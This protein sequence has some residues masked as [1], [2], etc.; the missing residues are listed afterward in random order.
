MFSGHSEGP[1]SGGCWPLAILQPRT[2]ILVSFALDFHVTFGLK[3]R[4]SYTTGV[5]GETLFSRKACTSFQIQMLLGLGRGRAW[6]PTSKPSHPSLCAQRTKEVTSDL[7]GGEAGWMADGRWERDH[8]LTPTASLS[9]ISWKQLWVP[10]VGNPYA[11]YALLGLW[12]GARG[13]H[14][15]SHGPLAMISVPQNRTPAPVKGKCTG[16]SLQTNPFSCHRAI[17]SQRQLSELQ[18]HL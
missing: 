13:Y 17:A 10:P 4:G 18:M 9:S 15:A 12:N 6:V 5:E 8:C 3:K 16:G 11:G 7:Q 2:S 1:G 14:F